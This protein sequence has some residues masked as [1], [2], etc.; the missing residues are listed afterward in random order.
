MRIRLLLLA[1]T[2]CVSAAGVACTTHPDIRF[3]MH[4]TTTPEAPLGVKCWFPTVAIPRQKSAW[5]SDPA[6]YV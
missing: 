3:A 1:A 5:L 6:F 4:P 2:A